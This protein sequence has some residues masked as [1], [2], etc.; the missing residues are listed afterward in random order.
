MCVCVAPIPNV[1]VQ[2]EASAA[3]ATPTTLTA[4][5]AEEKKNGM[6][7]AVPINDVST[8]QQEENVSISGSNARLMIMKK[9]SRKSQAR[10]TRDS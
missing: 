8:L 3:A 6:S 7:P 2:A 5:T 9:L 4:T 1:T 10:K